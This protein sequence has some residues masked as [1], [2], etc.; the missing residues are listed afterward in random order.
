MRSAAS[1]VGRRWAGALA[2][3]AVGGLGGLAFGV[4]TPRGPATTA[5]ALATMAI[6]I[7]L[8]VA[9]GFAMRSRWALLVAPLVFAVV[10]ELV[11][12]GESGPTVDAVRLGSLYGVVAFATGRG[13]HGVLALL[14]MLVG[15][16]AGAALARRR[17]RGETPAAGGRRVARYARTGVLGVA[18]AALI[19]LAGLIARPAGTDQIRGPDGQVLPG[20]VAE[21]TTIRAGGQDQAVMIRG[22]STGNPVLLFLAG[23]PGGTEI[24]TMRNLGAG[25]EEDFVVATW[26]QRG[27]GKSAGAREPVEDLTLERIV[28]DTIEIADHLRRRFGEERIY[29][30]GNSWGTLVGVLAVQRSPERFHA[31][32][33]TGQMVSVRETDRM[34]WEDT[35]AWAERTGDTGL[36]DRL[37]AAGEPPYERL[38]LYE[39]I[40][41]HERD[42]NVYPDLDGSRDQAEMSSNLFVREYS[43]MEQLRAMGAFLDAFSVL[44]PQIQDLDLRRDVPAL[45][46]PVFL[47]HGRHEARGRDVVAREWFAA[48]SAPVKRLVLFDHSG[49]KPLFEEP[50]RFRAVMADVVAHVGGPGDV[51][52]ADR[53]DATETTDA[54][55]VPLAPAP[56]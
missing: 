43:L 56:E 15:A 3:A 18:A 13:L 25:L 53:R 42:W 24:G 37:R 26:D 33:G 19:V 20:S 46:V 47:V 55:P 34:F 22:H 9:A 41:A 48:L 7:A 49:H 28:A 11:R 14:P 31:Y 16:A 10:F 52:P 2:A 35:I 30:V 5:E 6:C 39:P 50:E 51:T 1:V 27:A 40:S 36:A 21:L 32:V 17:E 4:V 54:E 38:W 23:G 12:I 8:G 45:Q 29:L 44:Y